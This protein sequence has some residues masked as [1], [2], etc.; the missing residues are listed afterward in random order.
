M[1]PETPIDRLFVAGPNHP[2]HP[3]TGCSELVRGATSMV[4]MLIVDCRR[5]RWVRAKG[6]TTRI[7]GAIRRRRMLRRGSASHHG[8]NFGRW[9]RR[10]GLTFCGG[11]CGVLFQQ[12]EIPKDTCIEVLGQCCV[13]VY[14]GSEVFA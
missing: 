11:F 8:G 10:L 3:S 7:G 4:P 9:Q 6:R 2:K 1:H 12:I 5:E 14:F 13:V